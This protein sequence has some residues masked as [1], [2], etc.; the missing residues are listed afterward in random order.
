MSAR[1]SRAKTCGRCGSDQDVS[2]SGDE[3]VWT[4]AACDENLAREAEYEP[5]ERDGACDREVRS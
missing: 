1:A 5:D 2:P 4:C 3:Y